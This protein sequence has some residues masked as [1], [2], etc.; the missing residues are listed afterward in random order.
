MSATVR[1]TVSHLSSFNSS[2][3]ISLSSWTASHSDSNVE[4]FR[5]TEM[6]GVFALRNKGSKVSLIFLMSFSTESRRSFRVMSDLSMA[7]MV[8]VISLDDWD[9]WRSSRISITDV[10]ALTSNH[11]RDVFYRI[12]KFVYLVL[13]KKFLSYAPKLLIDVY[14]RWCCSIIIKCRQHRDSLLTFPFSQPLG[15]WT[16][17]CCKLS[18]SGTL[19]ETEI[20]TDA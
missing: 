9:L 4:C 7:P 14:H 20:I 10:R 6:V 13:H 15:Q 19:N 17:S 8:A 12:C 11:E 1:N 5:S 18:F 3:R 16:G 2:F